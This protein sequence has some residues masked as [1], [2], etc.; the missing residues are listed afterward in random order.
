MAC[1]EIN[2]HRK[3]QKSERTRGVEPRVEREKQVN[4]HSRLQRQLDVEGDG[5]AGVHVEYVQHFR[6]GGAPS[7]PTTRLKRPARLKDPTGIRRT[8]HTRPGSAR[9]RRHEDPLG[10]L[11]STPAVS[12]IGAVPPVCQRE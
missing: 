10:H 11:R 8:L 12:S 9:P 6:A 1:S 7:S 4:D 5:G 2:K 3:R